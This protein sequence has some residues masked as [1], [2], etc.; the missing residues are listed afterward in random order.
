MCGTLL[1]GAVGQNNALSNKEVGPP[2]NRDGVVLT[3]PDG[4]PQTTAQP[5][6]LLRFSPALFAKEAS[7]MFEH[8]PETNRLSLRKGKREPWLRLE[9]HNRADKNATW[10]YCS[11]CKDRY[12]DTGKRQHGHIPYRDRASQ[13]LMRTHAPRERVL[14]DTN[15]TQ[16][17]PEREPEETHEVEP[18]EPEIGETQAAEVVELS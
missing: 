13:F 17:E 5:P 16:E 15:E 12:F 7:A 1:H 3:N 8:D 10:L 14:H 9:H 4:T 11:D 6:F 2:T 18:P